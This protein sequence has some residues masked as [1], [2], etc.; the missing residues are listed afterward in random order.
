MA[1][2]PF[3]SDIENRNVLIIGGQTVALA[4]A[5]K[6]LEFGARVKVVST[7]I[8]EEL[9]SLPIEIVCRQY[10]DADITEDTDIV[11]SACAD[12]GLNEHIFELCRNRKIPLNVVDDKR[13]CTFIFPAIVKREDLVIGISTSGSSPIAARWL[14]R[15]I[16][17]I[18]PE[19]FG[20]LL[21]YMAE[22]RKYVKDVSS[23]ERVRG[24][25]LKCI[26][27]KCILSN[28]IISEKERD[29]IVDNVLNG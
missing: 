1:F 22:Q 24:E 20:E 23:E 4:K 17:D 18:V 27:E 19:N 26:F 13:L 29:E 16:S 11:I 10:V 12:A 14:K 25:I 7:T 28:E 6:M 9:K 2:F 5:K 8:C 15:E 21:E 3:Y